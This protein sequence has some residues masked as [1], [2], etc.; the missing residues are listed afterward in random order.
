MPLHAKEMLETGAAALLFAATFLAGGHVRVPPFLMGGV[1]GSISFGG[2]MSIAYVFVHVMPELHD[3]RHAFATSVSVPLRYEGMAIYFV[4]LAGFMLFY[5]LDHLRNHL[6][7]AV[8]AGEGRP[9]FRIHLGG[10]TPY[11]LLM[12]YLLV[13]NLDEAPAATALYT[14]AIVFHFKSIDRSLD[15]EHGHA[16]QRV[17]RLVLG[18]AALLGWGLGL[19]FALPRDVLALLMAFVSGSIIM[20]SAIMELSLEKR[21]RFWPFVTGGLVYGLVLLPLG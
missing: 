2:G 11:V 7:D 19:L 18:G 16:Y 20:N 5:A 17:G 12:A 21:E 6:R 1:R 15:V 14:V 10:F 4:A 13:R 9:A 8:P 3:V